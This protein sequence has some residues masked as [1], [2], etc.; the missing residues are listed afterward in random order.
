M[1][2]SFDVETDASAF[3]KKR[4]CTQPH[5]NND[6]VLGELTLAFDHHHPRLDAVPTANPP[7]IVLE[8]FSWVLLDGRRDILYVFC[9]VSHFY[10]ASAQRRL[11]HT[12]DLCGCN[13]RKIRSWCLAVTRH[14]DL[15]QRVHALSLSLPYNLDSSDIGKIGCALNR[16]VNL[17]ELRMLNQPPNR[18]G[19]QPFSHSNASKEWRLIDKRPFRLTKFANTYFEHK[20]ST[21]FWKMQP[22]I[23]LLSIPDS[24]TFPYTNS[25][26]LGNLV[27]LEAR[28]QCIGPAGALQHVLIHLHDGNKDFGRDLH[29][30]ESLRR[31]AET[32]HTVSIVRHRV[33]NISTC[34]IVKKIAHLLPNLRHFNITERW[35]NVNARPSPY[36]APHLTQIQP[37]G[38]VRE[39]DSVIH[40]MA[41]LTAIE[42]FVLQVRSVKNVHFKGESSSGGFDMGSSDDLFGVGLEIME[43]C[44]TLMRVEIGA[45]VLEGGERTCV[46]TRDESGV[47]VPA[48]Y[49]TFKF[50]ATENFYST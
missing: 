35:E 7:E 36:N 33:K 37:A 12:V 32:L 16:C 43:R 6:N 11:Y 38:I 49:E 46:L 29:A 39:E 41:Q 17:K 13:M 2:R 20:W 22:E 40:T 47:F 18:N 8:I 26:G 9:R 24:S 31:H 4:A 3:S 27:A 42:S 34:E 1:R 19:P 28:P 5:K 21:S 15:A 14:D 23:R 25:G 50:D 10:G 30:L 45:D 48:R 44:S